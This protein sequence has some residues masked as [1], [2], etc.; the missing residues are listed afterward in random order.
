MKF[1]IAILIAI[2]L[3]GCDS[4][5]SSK[6]SLSGVRVFGQDNSPY[7]GSFVRGLLACGATPATKPSE[8]Q[9]V[10]SYEALSNSRV[11]RMVLVVRDARG[12]VL[13]SIWPAYGSLNM[14]DDAIEFAEAFAVSHGKLESDKK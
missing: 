8:A 1:A 7:T 2:A 5:P 4:T 12:S 11:S 3:V 6:P 10:V 13:N 14:S 9:L